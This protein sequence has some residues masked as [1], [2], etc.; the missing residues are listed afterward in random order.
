MFLRYAF[1]STHAAQIAVSCADVAEAIDT[2]KPFHTAELP[3]PI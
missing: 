1:M 2:L 3:R